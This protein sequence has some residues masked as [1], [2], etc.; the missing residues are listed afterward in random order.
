MRQGLSYEDDKDKKGRLGVKIAVFASGRGTNFTAIAKAV[1]KGIIKADLALLVCDNPQAAVI[2]RAKEAGV[3]IFLITEKEFSGRQDFEAKIIA[4]LRENKIDLLVLAGFMRLL[5]A[6][7]VQQYRGRI[8]NIHPALLPA[9]KGKEGIK[10]A[11][12]YGAKVAGVTVHFVDEKTDHGP[13]ILQKAVEIKGM[14]T[15]DSLKEKIHRLEHWLYPQAIK[16]FVEGKLRIDG[17]K[18]SI[19]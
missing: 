19:R 2:R 1:K 14:D 12:N 17:R 13:I 9:F 16:L 3:K 8:I 15:L 6:G 5:S 18:V 11:F 10:D 7:F 4:S